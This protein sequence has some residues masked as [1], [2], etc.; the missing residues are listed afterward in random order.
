VTLRFDV[1]DDSG[2]SKTIVRIYESRSLL[3]TRVS[4][5]TFEIGTRNVAIRWQVPARLRSRR[6]RFCVVA[7]DPAGNRSAPACALFIRV[8]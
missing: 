3:A 6:L 2:R 8:S 1:F 7:V 5:M 4:P